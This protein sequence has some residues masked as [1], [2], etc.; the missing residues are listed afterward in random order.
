MN[1]NLNIFEVL[2]LSD[3][4]IN[5]K[6]GKKMK[7]II[8]I[9]EER[10]MKKIMVICFFAVLS[11]VLV[12]GSADAK[13]KGECVN[14]HTMHASQGGTQNSNWDLTDSPA[15]PRARLLANTCEG[16]HTAP[17]SDP[18]GSIGD[19]NLPYVKGS[20]LGANDHL[21]GGYFS[22]DTANDQHDGSSHTLTSTATPAGYSGSWYT[23]T[24]DG[25][26]CAGTA[27]C[28][29]DRSESDEFAAIGGGHHETNSNF[30]GAY[31]FLF[32]GTDLANDGVDGTEAADY[33][34]ALID[35]SG[36]STGTNNI[37]TGENSGATDNDTV[38]ELCGACHT[39]FHDSIGSEGAWTRHPV[40]RQI[41]S[42]WAIIASSGS[43]Y[44]HDDARYNPLGFVDGNEDVSSGNAVVMCL[45]CHR[46]HGSQY[47]DNLRFDY[48]AQDADGTAG[49]EDGCLGCHSK[50]R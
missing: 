23:G 12:M 36:A 42:D 21:A 13:V 2:G 10:T 41:P 28:H 4:I 39:D 18:Y 31:R 5:F 15:A 35:T 33:E 29:G 34:E 6:E 16:C 32:V 19:S 30:T 17:A 1:A 20:G 14:C 3:N 8:K 37:Y 50:Q 43:E 40:D 22:D 7:K 45:S 46:A 38:S 24:S 26:S 27:G 47:E 48:T 25:L 49:V 11:V 44:D 9:K